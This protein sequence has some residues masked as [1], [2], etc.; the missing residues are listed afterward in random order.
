[1]LHYNYFTNITSYN[2]Y[3][4]SHKVGVT[5]LPIL[6]VRNVCHDS[7]SNKIHALLQK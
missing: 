4:Q 3:P 2:V 6:Q 7:Y 1:M 5:T